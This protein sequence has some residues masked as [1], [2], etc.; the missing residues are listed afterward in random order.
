MRGVNGSTA[1]LV[2]VKPSGLR[3]LSQYYWIEKIDLKK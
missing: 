1:E 2:S 3:A